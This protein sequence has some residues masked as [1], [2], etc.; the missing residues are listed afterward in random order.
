MEGIFF[1]KADLSFEDKKL[2]LY[3]LRKWEFGS[4]DPA[5]PKTACYQAAWFASQLASISG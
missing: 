1:F 5:A 4:Q 2:E 3:L